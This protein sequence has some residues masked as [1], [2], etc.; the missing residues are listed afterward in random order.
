MSFNY[1]A[2]TWTPHTAA[3]HAANLLND[4]NAQLAANNIRD[5]NGNIVVLQPVAT[6]AVWLILLAMGAM[7]A[8]DDLALL[9]ASQMFSISESSD[10]Q[11]QTILPLAGTSL[12]AGA[13][14]QVTLT[15]TVDA[16]GATITPS[17][18]APF[19]TICNFIPVT[20]TVIPPSGSAQIL[21]QS[22]TIGPIAVAPGAITAF[23]PS[24]PHV[25]SVN[26]ANAAVVG[27][28][29]E[30]VTQ[31]RQ[32]LLGSQI[33][34]FSLDGTINAVKQVQGITTATIYLNQSPTNN[35]I[36]PGPINV[37]PLKAYIVLSGTDITGV[38]IA[39]AYAKRMLVDTFSVGLTSPAPYTRTDIS[40]ALSDNSINTAAG[41]FITAG[42]AVGQWVQITDGT[43]SP[44]NNNVIGLVGSV[45]ATKIVLTNCT[46]QT[47]ASGSSVT[48]TAKNAQPFTT[49]S[50][51]KIPIQYDVAA[52]QNVYVKVFYEIGSPTATGYDVSIKNTVAAIQWQ[53]G[54]HV[55]AALVM[56]ALAGFQFATI[57]GAQVSLDNVNFFNEVIPNGN[58]LP[59]IPSGNIQVVVG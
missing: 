15:V 39:N 10:G 9:A 8:D 3:E 27:R 33:N 25:T 52:A 59:S 30:T 31:V 5:A 4:L 19:G 34:D 57:T 56:Q 36:L 48:L 51:Q 54:Q 26:N 14:S 2:G 35:L 50:G 38:A 55:T 22:D 44:L 23:S 7:R 1:P 40:F 53:I 46:I 6:N 32:R 28:N 17:A 49:T 29:A 16:T 45:T 24:I 12:I 43:P 11:I 20:T 58:A 47:E 37:P 41:N 18:K 13:F 21:C 42:F